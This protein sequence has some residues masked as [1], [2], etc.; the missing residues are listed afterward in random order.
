MAFQN[1][2][3]CYSFSQVVTHTSL[4]K[5]SSF[6]CSEVLITNPTSN[7]QLLL[8]YDNN[9]S[10][11]ARAFAINAGD[12]ISVRGVTSSDLLSA[13]FAA[14]PTGGTIYCRSQFYSHSTISYG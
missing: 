12:T 1:L 14:S 13:K 3:Q 4:A 10:T 7:A 8:I 9:N 11:D 2:N 5:L 6:P